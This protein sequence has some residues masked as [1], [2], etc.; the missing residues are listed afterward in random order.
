MKAYREI[1]RRFQP[2]GRAAYWRSLWRALADQD[3]WGSAAQL[4]FYLCFA[5]FPALLALLLFLGYFELH[6]IEAA[7]TRLLAASLPK[8]TIPLVIDNVR[9]LASQPRGA[10]ASISIVASFAILIRAIAVIGRLLDRASG[11]RDSRSILQRLFH[12]SLAVLLVGMIAIV[13]GAVVAIARV[14]FNRHAPE[15][16]S[17]WSITRHGIVLILYAVALSV[18][19]ALAPGGARGWHWISPGPLLAAIAWGISGALLRLAASGLLDYHVLYGSVAAMIL[20][21]VWIYL[22]SLSILVGAE[23]ET[24]IAAAVSV[25]AEGSPGAAIAAIGS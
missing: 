13:C 24:R 20:L 19:Y 12:H 16:L 23:I 15:L 14:Q 8:E 5:L 18:A 21:L 22:T 25:T 2:L 4:S 11:E 3:I 6:A 1:E 9:E 7:I 10:V 17:W